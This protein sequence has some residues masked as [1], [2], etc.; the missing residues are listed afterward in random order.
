[1]AKCCSVPDFFNW[2]PSCPSIT[3]D[4]Q[5][6]YV[7]QSSK[8]SFNCIGAIDVEE[9]WGK[10]CKC[11]LLH[12]SHNLRFYLSIRHD[13]QF[14]QAKMMWK[15][16]WPFLA[17]RQ[18]THGSCNQSTA[19]TTWDFL[20]W[21]LLVGIIM[22][23]FAAF[24]HSLHLLHF[25]HLLHLLHP[26]PQNQRREKKHNST[27][28]QSWHLQVHSPRRMAPEIP[29]VFVRHWSTQFKSLFQTYQM[30]FLLLGIK[31]VQRVDLHKVPKKID[32]FL[33]SRST[34]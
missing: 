12:C 25:L 22:M 33:V 14:S 2:A 5:L 21:F 19:G 32:S 8:L 11:G 20:I 28:L 3:A 13:I 7:K 10:T 34:T 23:F 31:L 15:S 9:C 1:M 29:V 17:V 24:F 6:Y 18:H 4:V 16:R 26:L 30:R 27:K